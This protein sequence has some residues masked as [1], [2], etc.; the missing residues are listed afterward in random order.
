MNGTQEKAVKPRVPFLAVM[1]GMGQ[2][3]KEIVVDSSK[4][5]V[6]FFGTYEKEWRALQRAFTEVA[7]E[8]A[9]RRYIFRRTY[10]MAVMWQAFWRMIWSYRMYKI[11]SPL[12]DEQQNKL[13]LAKLHEEHAQKFVQSAM[14]LKGALLKI[15]QF[16]S[17]RMDL[18][19]APYVKSLSQLQ[20]SVP[21]VDFSLIER[22]IKVSLGAEINEVFSSFDE[23]PVAA[24]SI[25]QVHYAVL[26]DGREVAVKIQY[27][28][29]ERVVKDDLWV[30]LE[31]MDKLE[32]MYEG[33]KVVWIARE[34]SK[35]IEQELDY[36]QEAKHLKTF[37][38]IFENN[39][40]VIVPD[41]ID[42]YTT[43]EV[44]V[45]ERV[46]G[47]K[48]TDWLDGEASLDERK[49]LIRTMLDAFCFQIL[50]HG[51]FHADPHP[52][53]FLVTEDRKLVMVDFG[54]CKIFDEK[55]RKGFQGLAQAIISQN[56]DEMKKSFK[57]IGFKMKRGKS[58]EETIKK[59]ALLFLEV[60]MDRSKLGDAQIKNE[61]GA[62]ATEIKN[63][64][65]EKIPQDFVLLGRVFTS[66][67]GLLE[68]YTPGE[69]YED[70]MLPYL[71]AFPEA[72][73]VKC[74]ELENVTY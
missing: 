54:C 31:V 23:E 10:R 44:L 5:L 18:L 2:F 13:R 15:G 22:Q 62:I 30:L 12:Y 72:E 46:H 64:P 74:A 70:V 29:I 67:G 45:M 24:A 14:H 66:L 42:E 71:F 38:K 56:V 69:R 43:K 59:L 28:D 26:R 50:R 41:V 65:F 3:G 7:I 60:F 58:Y 9:A 33:V 51:A 63:N 57:A 21:P 47:K 11:K 32:K 4:F 73:R 35:Y 17:T 49:A 27:P 39:A 52:G 53:N 6:E 48:I 25:G 61:F 8:L 55:V 16:A 68:K 37:K 40:N 1:L 20:D 19:P 36:L 34:L